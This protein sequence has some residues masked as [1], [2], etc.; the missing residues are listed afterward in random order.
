[1]RRPGILA[2]FGSMALL[3]SCSEGSPTSPGKAISAAA[4]D[5]V[6]ATI[7]KP[8][9]HPRTA[10]VV[11]SRGGGPLPP[12]VW[13]SDKA[14][15]TIR[16]GSATLDIFAMSFPPGGC[17]GSYG[18]VVA[19]IPNGRFSIGGTYTQLIGAYPG[20][21]A[22][23]SVLSGDVEGNRM[24]IT[25][26]VPALQTAYGPFVLISGVTNSWVGCQYP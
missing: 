20:K 19:S 18:D 16:P 22:Y 23:A 1:M 9:G 14:S 25:I 5:T 11:A 24:T 21:I 12:G 8:G 26:S 2:L 13:G 15:L 7:V 10:G 6:E 4:G 3:V 17:Y